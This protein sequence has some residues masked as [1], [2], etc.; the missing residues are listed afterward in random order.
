MWA[1]FQNKPRCARLLA[2][3]ERDMKSAEG[4]TALDIPK[5]LGCTEIVSVPMVSDLF[6]WH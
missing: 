1:V 5:G 6:Y 3:K 4:E 2:K